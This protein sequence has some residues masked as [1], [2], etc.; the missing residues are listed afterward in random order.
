[1][2]TQ[3]KLAIVIGI[4]K[5]QVAAANVLHEQSVIDHLALVA[6]VTDSVKHAKDYI[7]GLKKLGGITGTIGIQIQ[8]DILDKLE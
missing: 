5:Q 6:T 2:Q 8:L 3:A 4:V 1:M 7:A